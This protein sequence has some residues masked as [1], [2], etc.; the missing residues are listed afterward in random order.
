MSPNNILKLYNNYEI[1][2]DAKDTTI[3]KIR[4]QVIKDLP[5]LCKGRKEHTQRIADI[6][7]RLLQSDDTTEINV[8]TNSL[9][10]VLKSD[11]KGA[12]TGI[13]GQIHRTTNGEVAN[14]IL[15]ARC[16][17]FLATQVK[18]LGRE[19][20]NKEAEELIIYECKKILKNVVAEEFEH[21]MELL[22]WSRLGKTPAGKREL[23]QLVA[24]LAFSQEDWHP[25]DPKY[26]DRLIECSRHALP[27]FSS[28]VDSSQFVKFFCDHV[29]TRWD[30]IT[31]TGGHA[32]SKLEL[33]KILAEITEF[34]RDVEKLQEKI[35][36]VY[37]IL[38]KYLP[39]FPVATKENGADR[40]NQGTETKPEECSATPSLQFSHMECVLFALHSL[41]RI[42]PETLGADT[43]RLRTLRL[44]LQ[45]TARLTQGA[46][47]SKGQQDFEENEL[48][49]PAPKTISN[50]NILIGDIF[51]TPLRIKSKVQLSFQST[52]QPKKE[53]KQDNAVNK[54]KLV[55][56]QKRHRPITF[57]N[58]DENFASEK[59]ART[60]DNIY[61]PSFRKYS[62]RKGLSFSLRGFKGREWY[63]RRVLHDND[64]TDY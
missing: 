22:T 51:R 58:D 13:F 62:S 35:I 31:T 4:K 29:L 15:R 46:Q 54:D 11:P 59:R 25:E 64:A 16:I 45:Y 26:V 17:K 24:S 12:L 44:R 5:K 52:K 40:I 32:D 55:S 48:E 53:E 63:G 14:E 30:D 10:S 8:V 7:S 60:S 18:Q 21:I 2:A 39:E 47:G 1:F 36:A 28:Q 61:K 38:L 19:I 23:V 9:R 27:L 42:S 56:A 50:I 6:L 20:I 37:D 43:V 57:D 34:C 3:S 41:C 33:L 49:I